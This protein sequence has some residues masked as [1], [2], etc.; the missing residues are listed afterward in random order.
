VIGSRLTDYVENNTI[1]IN[2]Q[3]GFRKKMSTEMATIKLVD[4][5]NTSFE[6][7]LIPAALFLDLK[8]AF[9]TIDHKQLL[10]E[11]EKIGVTGKSLSWFES[12]LS[13]RKQVVV[14]GCFTSEASTITCGVPQGSILGPLLFLIFI[15]RIKYYLSEAGI[16]LFADDTLLFVAAPSV[17]LLFDKMIKAMTEFIEWADFNLLT[18]NYNKTNY[19]LFPRISSIETNLELIINGNQIKRVK[20]TKYLGFMIDE[21][22]SWKTHSNIIASKLSRSLGVLRRVKNLVSYKILRLLYFAIFYPYICYGCSLWAS[23]FVS[24]YKKIQKIQ[25]KA[26]KLLSPKTLFTH[27]INELYTK[28]Q[29]FDI[30]KTRDY[31][32]SI[33]TYKF[34]N[35]I[36]PSSFENFFSINCDLHSHNTRGASNLV[37]PFRNTARAS[38]VI[39]NFAPSVWDIIPIE[40]RNSSHLTSL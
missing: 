35:N 25:N 29:L 14:N 19:I 24:C 12:Y 2:T 39:R 36:L 6:A 34:I 18:L 37:H 3:F 8:K 15:D 22:L 5:V 31:Q 32:V 27:N 33:F 30:S 16:I 7:G 13:D 10:L 28:N 38:F 9:D 21:N 4:W 20:V 26:V 23:N 11:L 40:I 1:L 17:D